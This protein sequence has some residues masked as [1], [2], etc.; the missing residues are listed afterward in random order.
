MGS[1]EGRG[2]RSPTGK[3]R[4]TKRPP[5]CEILRQA[6]AMPRGGG[7]G[8]CKA[9]GGKETR[10]KGSPGRHGLTAT[11]A[12]IHLLYADQATDTTP[13][14]QT[15][16]RDPPCF[17]RPTKLRTRIAWL[18]AFSVVGI[19]RGHPGR[20]APGAPATGARRKGVRRERPAM[21]S[22][23]RGRGGRGCGMDGGGREP[24]QGEGQEEGEEL[25]DDPDH[26][27]ASQESIW[28]WGENTNPPVQH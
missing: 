21:G 14:L 10:G 3:G 1:Q 12:V 20:K 28:C 19:G 26:G 17:A 15:A 25:S 16:R 2:A 5:A 24:P 22:L 6:S 18:G 11:G 8:G 9:W 7:E 23:R 27:R 4:R 13:A